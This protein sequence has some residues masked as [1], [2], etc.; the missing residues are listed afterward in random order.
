MAGIS[1]TIL[2]L[3][4]VG[5]WAAP[6]LAH[7]GMVI[8][9]QDV[10][11]DKGKATVGL[12]V[13]FSHPMEGNGM[14]MAKPKAFGVKSGDQTTDLLG[15]LKPA[16][17]LDHAGWAGEYVFKRPGVGT[18][19]VV[20]EPYFEPAEDKYIEHITKVVVPAFGEEEGWDEPVG[21]PAEIVPLTRPF[22]NYAGNVFTGK[23]LVDG[24]PAAGVTVEVEYDNKD[25]AYEAPN[26]YLTT[27]VVKT[28]A[29]G[30]FSYAV[31]FSGWWG[32]AALTDAP[33]TIQKDGA[34]KK[35]ERG[36]VLWTKF[37][38]PKRKKK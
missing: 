19:F 3:A 6:A 24:K 1:R 2:A 22:G 12:T 18:F 15:T 16:K 35:V 14:D 11:T 7:F 20:P 32:F 9:S 27:Q 23:V 25:K 38:E 33:E 31:P 37:L 36:A 5:L 34:A 8:P 13:S 17:V 29:N 26:E 28:D 4:V 30:V 10:V 21:L